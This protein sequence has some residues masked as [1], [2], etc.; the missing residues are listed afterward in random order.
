MMV[1]KNGKWRVCIDFINLNKACPKDSFLLPKIDM[2]VDVITGHKLLSF[3]DAYSGYNQILMYPVDQEKTLFVIERGIFYYKVISFG[4]KNARA[5]YQGL[6]NKLFFEFLRETMKVY[7]DNMLVKSLCTTDHVQHLHQGFNILDFYQ[8][9][10]N[11]EKCTFKVLLGQ[12]LGH[13]VTQR[14]IKAHLGQ[15]KIVLN[16]PHFTNIKELQRLAK[17]IVALNKFM[18]RSTDRCVEVFRVL[19][20]HKTFD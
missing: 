17:Q 7:I 15:I 13:L 2:L 18:S 5:T 3:M 10:L 6:V 14:R 12:F 19:N 4:L 1:Q 16:M 8:M 9:K 20:N 11:H